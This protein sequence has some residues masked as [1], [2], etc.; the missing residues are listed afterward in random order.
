MLNK[1]EW[2]QLENI[3]EKSK[4]EKIMDAF[5][6]VYSLKMT[7]YMVVNIMK[8]R[9]FLKLIGIAP[10]APSA[11]A[12]MPKKELTVAAARECSVLLWSGVG[13]IQDWK[14]TWSFFDYDYGKDKWIFV[15][16]YEEES[17]C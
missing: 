12:A 11:L 17:I 2:I 13:D 14:N 9:D 5:G 10:I 16:A 7:Q 6:N 15:K 1:D 8:R 4:K 3:V